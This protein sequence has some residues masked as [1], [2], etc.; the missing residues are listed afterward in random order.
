MPENISDSGGSGIAVEEGPGIP[1][2][3]PSPIMGLGTVVTHRALALYPFSAKK[4]S[5]L[6]FNKGDTINVSET[7]ASEQVFF[8]F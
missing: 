8:F 3:I 1:A 7:Q 5:Q 6:S 2:D 4:G